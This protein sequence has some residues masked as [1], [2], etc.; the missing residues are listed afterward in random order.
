MKENFWVLCY[1][2]HNARQF[3]TSKLQNVILRLK[4]PETFF[5]FAYPS[6]ANIWI[7]NF[8]F[9]R[10]SIFHSMLVRLSIA[11]YLNCLLVQRC[12]RM[13]FDIVHWCKSF[14][15]LTY[16][17]TSILKARNVSLASLM[18]KCHHW[19]YWDLRTIYRR[20][21]RYDFQSVK[22]C[23][24][25]ATSLLHKWGIKWL[26]NNSNRADAQSITSS[27]SCIKW[28]LHIMPHKERCVFVFY[29]A[30]FYSAKI[31]S[32]LIF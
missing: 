24:W 16:H 17:V 2:L 29:V 1:L 27:S 30:S 10:I 3:F 25:Y 22:I 26:D 28:R 7:A 13:K 15:F 12:S 31:V 18:A 14:M 5:V 32:S 20:H 9:V 4:Y 6:N 19:V 23:K 8:I 21:N 11:K